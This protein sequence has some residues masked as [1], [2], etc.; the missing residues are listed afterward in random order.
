[1]NLDWQKSINE[2]ISNHPAKFWHIGD[3][4]V[5]LTD[6][7]W[8]TACRLVKVDLPDCLCKR[9]NLLSIVNDI[10]FEYQFGSGHWSLSRSKKLF[11]QLKPFIPR[12]LQI[13]LRQ[14]YRSFQEKGKALRISDCG[15]RIGDC[16]NIETL[17]WPIEDRYVRF[18]Y[19]LV[20]SL[21]EKKGLS[22][23]P[24]IAFWPEG[25]EFAFVLTHDVETEEGFKAIPKLVE[26]DKQYGFR[27]IFNIVPERYPI[28]RA[29]LGR[30]RADG[31]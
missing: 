2:Y 12:F 10:L 31:F 23:L 29:Y 4:L 28:D 19:E 14:I 24:H 3:N 11:Y 22:E 9:D 5:D 20:R 17:N 21:I 13:T 26:V 18:Q 7:D 30:L 25:K 27:S 16:R 8:N 15:F 1:M 6:T